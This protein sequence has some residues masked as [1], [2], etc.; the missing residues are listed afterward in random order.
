MTSYKL[1]A[2]V[3]ALVVGLTVCLP[4]VASA[5][6]LITQALKL[7]G[8]SYVVRRFGPQINSFINNLAGQRGVKWEGTT[9]VVP[10]FSVGQGAFVGAAQVQGPSDR[11][12]DVRAVAQIETRISNLRG[13]L[14]IPA[15]TSNPT[16]NVSRI[17][18]VGI[19]ALIDFKI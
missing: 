7:F 11:V 1:V 17:Q 19:S 13:R 14:M 12:N 18:G 3:L 16:K 2:L 8:I 10:I 4:T 15:N 6:G 9:K 5:Q